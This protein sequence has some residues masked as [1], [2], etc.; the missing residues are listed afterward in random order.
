MKALRSLDDWHFEVL[1]VLEEKMRHYETVP[2]D[3]V[4]RE[5]EASKDLTLKRLSTL[6]RYG[7]VWAPRGRERG[8]VL[9]YNG[10]DAIALRSVVNR[11]ILVS[12]GGR[13]GAGKESEV[14]EAVTAEEERVAVKF[15]R[16]GSRSFKKYKRHRDI[17]LHSHLYM[18]A[19]RLAAK[20]ELEAL[21]ILYPRGI[22]V[23]R[24]IY[25][26][27]H[28]LVTELIRGIEL[29]K[30]K[31]VDDPALLLEKVLRNLVEAFRAGVVN[32]DLSA[33]NVIYLPESGDV[34]L[35]DWPQW[36]SPDHATAKFYLRRDIDNVLEFFERRLHHRPNKDIMREILGEN[37]Y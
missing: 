6:H 22:K 2:T 11:G 30:V 23:P 24:P 18:E 9:N 17:A 4:A 1:R 35:I 34:F 13:I 32:C 28:L 19:S 27:R 7:L 12:I 31:A 8:F 15:Y 29:A 36:V 10:L 16:M 20:R 37:V 21:Q 33:Y 25:R 5:T 14:Y 3:V 26:N